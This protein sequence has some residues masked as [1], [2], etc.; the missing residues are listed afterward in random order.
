MKAKTATIVVA[1]NTKER[2]KEMAKQR[3][4]ELTGVGGFADN[5][6]IAAMNMMEK[7]NK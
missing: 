2:L 4:H 6:L 1:H 5:L 7:E 3:K